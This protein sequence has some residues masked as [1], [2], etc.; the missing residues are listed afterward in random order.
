MLNGRLTFA[1]HRDVHITSHI[2]YAADPRLVP[3]SDDA[4][5]LISN[6]DIVVDSSCPNNVRIYAHMIATGNRTSTRSDGSFGVY[7]Y[8]RGSPRGGLYVHGGIAQDYRGAVGTFST[9]T[10]RTSTGFDKHYTYDTRFASD[11][12][13]NYPPLSNRLHSGLW[14]DR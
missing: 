3:S 1:T 2:T 13:P 5:G 8:N 9:R 6:R 7:N 12:P 4:L 10:G 11:P 14:R